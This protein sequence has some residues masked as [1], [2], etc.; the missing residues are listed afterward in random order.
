MIERKII[1]LEHQPGHLPEKRRPSMGFKV[2]MLTKI[3]TTMATD[4]YSHELH[5]PDL[6]QAE[7]G[8]G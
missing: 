4:F 2:D 8:R 7:A 1:K 5:G 3:M 6:R